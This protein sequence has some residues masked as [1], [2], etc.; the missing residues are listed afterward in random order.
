DD[1]PIPQTNTS[2][3]SELCPHLH[4]FW[5]TSP[6]FTHP[7]QSQARLT[8]EILWNELPKTRCIFFS[9]AHSIR[10]PQLSVLDL[11]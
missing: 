2:L 10:T 6:K 1:R 7:T 3:F 5:K 8:V 4:A 11:E 9:V